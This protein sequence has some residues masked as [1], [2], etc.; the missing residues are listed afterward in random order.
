MLRP[1]RLRTALHAVT[2]S[3][4]ACIL[5]YMRLTTFGNG[6]S[7]M[8]VTGRN[9]ATVVRCSTGLPLELRTRRRQVLGPGCKTARGLRARWLAIRV[10]DKCRGPEFGDDECFS[11][12]SSGRRRYTRDCGTGEVEISGTKTN[13]GPRTSRDNDNNNRVSVE[14]NTILRTAV[15]SVHGSRTV[16]LIYSTRERD[17][18]A[19]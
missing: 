11:Q 9:R 12:K 18:R 5:W 3:G 4:R 15:S 14:N 2:L 13:I 17:G 7:T 6:C 19:R 16:L 1:I 10:P 8:H